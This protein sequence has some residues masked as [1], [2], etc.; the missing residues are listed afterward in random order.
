MF[1]AAEDLILGPNLEMQRVIH[2]IL[3][4]FCTYYLWH[5]AAETVYFALSE[6]IICDNS[7]Y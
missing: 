5:V 1:V 7:V 3:A 2:F 6:L 4:Y